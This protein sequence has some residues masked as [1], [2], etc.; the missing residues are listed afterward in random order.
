[1]NDR[2]SPRGSDTPVRGRMALF[3]T[4]RTARARATGSSCFFSPAKMNGNDAVRIIPRARVGFH[5]L[6]PQAI[7]DFAIQRVE[8]VES[9]RNIIFSESD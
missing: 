9:A 6:P 3:L 2:T 8:S 1:M 5:L 4:V 7:G